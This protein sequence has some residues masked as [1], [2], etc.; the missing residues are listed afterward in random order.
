MNK[1]HVA[2][3]DSALNLEYLCELTERQVGMPVE[4]LQI[5]E[6]I[7]LQFGHA[8]PL[9]KFKIALFGQ[10]AQFGDSYQNRFLFVHDKDL[11]IAFW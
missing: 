1:M 11:S 3:P 9:R 4:D 8:E 6:L 2:Y 5:M 7:Q 10:A